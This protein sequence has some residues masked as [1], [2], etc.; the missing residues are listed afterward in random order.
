MVPTCFCNGPPVW[1]ARLQPT[2]LCSTAGLVTMSEHQRTNGA[3]S[4]KATRKFEILHQVSA[5][6]RGKDRLTRLDLHVALV[7]THWAGDDLSVWRSQKLLAEDLGLTLTGVRNALDRLIRCG[8]LRVLSGG[9]G[10]GHSTV[11]QFIIQAVEKGNSDCNIEA[12]KEQQPLHVTELKSA[13]AIPKKC[14]GSSNKS[15]TAIAP[16]PYRYPVEE[17]VEGN[18]SL[19]SP[20]EDTLD[21]EFQSVWKQYPRRTARAHALKAFK[22]ARKK[23]DLLT[24]MAGVMRYAAERGEQDPKF[25]KYMATWLNGE[26][27]DDEPTPRRS[28][29]VSIRTDA[30]SRTGDK[31]RDL[32]REAEEVS[33]P[34]MRTI[35]SA[36]DERP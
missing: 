7:L 16:T 26:C 13:T 28:D 2:P 6:C 4:S 25:T 8:H 33:L 21:G 31:S 18:I 3:A 27:W 29:Q 11:Y 12:A 34:L 35:S 17:P 20:D 32:L 19:H 5:D 15:T 1:E 22:A 9:L 10:R 30:K 36:D 23:V 24:I 14:N